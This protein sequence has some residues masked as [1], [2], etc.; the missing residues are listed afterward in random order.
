MSIVLGIKDWKF[1]SDMSFTFP[2]IYII[3]VVTK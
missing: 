1:G 3:I 2:L